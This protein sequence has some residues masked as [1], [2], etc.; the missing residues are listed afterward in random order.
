MLA[1]SLTKL[2]SSEIIE[3]LLRA[4][5]GDLPEI[6]GQD[7]AVTASDATWWASLVMKCVWSSKNSDPALSTS[8]RAVDSKGPSSALVA[9]NNQIETVEIFEKEEETKRKTAEKAHWKSTG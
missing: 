9:S 1:D 7:Q 6:P 8:L 2:A 3:R 4:L 5:L